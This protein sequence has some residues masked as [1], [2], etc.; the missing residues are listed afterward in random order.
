VLY[1]NYYPKHQH[2]SQLVIFV[3]REKMKEGNGTI[4]AVLDIL[5]LLYCI[6]AKAL[7]LLPTQVRN[8]RHSTPE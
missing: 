8:D 7:P 6:I 4:E 5:L 2:A 1:I 3:F